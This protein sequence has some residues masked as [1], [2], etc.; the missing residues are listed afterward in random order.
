MFIL[1]KE[2]NFKSRVKNTF[3]SWKQNGILKYQK[4]NSKEQESLKKKQEQ[5]QRKLK[6]EDGSLKR[7]IK[8]RNSTMQE[9]NRKQKLKNIQNERAINLTIIKRI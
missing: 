8:L 9:K 7:L 6:S 5:Q 4:L 3:L 1:E 2:I